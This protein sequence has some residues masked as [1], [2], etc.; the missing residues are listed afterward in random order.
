MMWWSTQGVIDATCVL[1]RYANVTFDLDRPHDKGAA[2]VN[3][4]GIAY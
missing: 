1:V 3:D 4:L 2:L